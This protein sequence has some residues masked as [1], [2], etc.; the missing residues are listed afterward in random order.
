[1]IVEM[2]NLS[3]MRRHTEQLP[4]SAH[5]VFTEMKLDLDAGTTDRITKMIDRSYHADSIYNSVFRHIRKNFDN[6]RITALIQWLRTPTTRKIVQL[7]IEAGTP[8][9][10]YQIGRLA[11][12]L[13]NNPPSESRMSL[14]RRLDSISGSSEFS[15]NLTVSTFRALVEVLNQAK[16][17][18]E[19]IPQ[20]QLTKAIEN[21]KKQLPA[22]SKAAT[23][24]VFLYTYR[25]LRDPELSEYIDYYLSDNGRWYW[26]VLTGGLSEALKTATARMARL[27]TAK[28]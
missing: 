21:M 18:D 25:S 24:V 19:Q 4:I 27:I 26:K 10:R 28:K 5:D 8:G 2:L 22:I 1:M 16:Q 14:I 13:R 7:E 23:S 9:A 17:D 11:A 15:V 20:V 6:A 3:G 12:Q